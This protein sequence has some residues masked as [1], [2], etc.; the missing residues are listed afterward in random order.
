MRVNDTHSSTR[1]GE[2][3]A[4]LTHALVRRNAE[5]TGHGPSK[6]RAFYNSNVVVVILENTMSSA[7]RSLAANG[8]A[9]L[10]LQMRREFQ[11]AMRADLVELVE[12]LSGCRVLAFLTDT[13]I[14][15]DL[16]CEVFVLDRP[17]PVDTRQA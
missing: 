13:S 4:L 2:F 11:L 14:D 10:V 15:P 5:F 7:E 16:A 1:G 8:N 17:V 3:N 6:A 12:Q 9:D